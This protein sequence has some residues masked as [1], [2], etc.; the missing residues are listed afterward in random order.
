MKRLKPKIRKGED[1]K[2]KKQKVDTHHSK[3][4]KPHLAQT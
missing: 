4:F 1:P 2:Q 3:V